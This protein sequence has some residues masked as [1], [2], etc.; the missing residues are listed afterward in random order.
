MADATEDEGELFA[1][2]GLSTYF[3]IEQMKAGLPP[4]TVSKALP[5]A[6]WN[7]DPCG[8]EPSLGYDINALP[9][10]RFENGVGPEAVVIPSPTQPQ[11]LT[12]TRASVE[13]AQEQ[14][15]DEPQRFRADGVPLS[16]SLPHPSQFKRRF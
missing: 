14:M 11:R 9:D 4:I 12:I 10:M 13:A 16:T 6:D 2:I 5:V 7:R 3:Q 8:Q 15:G 1:G